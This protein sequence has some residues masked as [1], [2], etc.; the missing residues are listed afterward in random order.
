[1]P[2]SASGE[3]STERQSFFIAD[4]SSANITGITSDLLR[5][6]YSQNMLSGFSH[7]HIFTAIRHF[8]V[9]AYSFY[10]HGF[11]FSLYFSD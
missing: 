3:S 2:F 8:F 10:Q 5:Q 9:Y 6:E 7:S 11:T 4:T 1:M